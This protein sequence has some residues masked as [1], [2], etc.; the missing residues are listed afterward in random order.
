MKNNELKKFA[1]KIACVVVSMT[2]KTEDFDF[3]NISLD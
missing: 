1:L 2:I 3:G